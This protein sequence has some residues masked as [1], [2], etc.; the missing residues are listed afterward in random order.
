MTRGM[1]LDNPTLRFSDKPEIGKIFEFK[2]ATEKH[3]I[4]ELA[5]TNGSAAKSSRWL[6]RHRTHPGSRVSPHKAI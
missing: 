2:G 1:Y 5:N 4:K 3:F 6:S